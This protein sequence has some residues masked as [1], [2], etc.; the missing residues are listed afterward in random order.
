MAQ[1]KKGTRCMLMEFAQELSGHL[2]FDPK[3]YAEYQ[4][5]FQDN[6]LTRVFYCYNGRVETRA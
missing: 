4:N 6:V 3:P 5:R 2:N 1:S